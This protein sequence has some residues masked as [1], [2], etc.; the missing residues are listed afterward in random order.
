MVHPGPRLLGPGGIAG[1]FGEKLV[2]TRL[3]LA[4]STVVVV[5]VVD[6]AVVAVTVGVDI[7]VG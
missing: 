4:G 7:G 3:A 1:K 5:V 6:T 2:W